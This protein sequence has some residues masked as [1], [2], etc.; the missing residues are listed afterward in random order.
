MLYLNDGRVVPW[1]GLTAVEEEGGEGQRTYYI[2]GRP[3][4][5]LP[6]PKEFSA[7]L[8]AYTYPDEFSSVMGEVQATDGMYL[9]SQ[10]GDSF[11]LAYRTLVGDGA[12]GTQAGYKIHIVYNVTVVPSARSYGT[13][14]N[15]IN[16]VEFQWAIQAVPVP[17]E[18][19]RA[20]AH[21]I[22][23][24]RNM[25]PLK[26]TAI[27]SLLYGDEVTDPS[28]PEIQIVFDTLSYGDAIIIVD[29]GDGTWDALG[30][31]ENIYMIGDG[32]FQI[33]NVDAVDN[34]DGT[35]DISSTP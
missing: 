16:P 31:Y 3:F 23:D 20:T 8:R 13:L 34:G 29:N 22:I 21:I 9:D 4:L 24:T 17:V 15:D 32:I 33:D 10:M 12:N 11:G 26:L 19:Y 28:L 5:Y 35:Y 18:G 27:E 6:Q 7:T 30:S 25:E 1:N 14:G 2:D